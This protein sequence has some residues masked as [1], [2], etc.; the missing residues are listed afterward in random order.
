MNEI[1]CLVNRWLALAA[2]G[3]TDI[4]P[5]FLINLH[6]KLQA[7]TAPAPP[8]QPPTLQ[9]GLCT[10]AA[11]PT[12]QVFAPVPGHLMGHP[13]TQPSQVQYVYHQPQQQQQLQRQALS[14]PTASPPMDLNQS[15]SVSLPSNTGTSFILDQ[16]PSLPVV[17]SPTPPAAPVTPTPSVA[18]SALNTPQK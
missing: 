15:L 4:P 14:P 7:P 2:S 18:S 10:T 11:Q 16:F 17:G 3:A 9:P 13:P 8:P 6:A 1:W 5:G 12:L